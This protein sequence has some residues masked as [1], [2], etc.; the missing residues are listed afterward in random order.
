MIVAGRPAWLEQDEFGTVTLTLT[1]DAS[2]ESVVCRLSWRDWWTI[3]QTIRAAFPFRLIEEG[4]E[5]R[6]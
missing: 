3:T 5:A 4:V 2:G 1:T 6:V